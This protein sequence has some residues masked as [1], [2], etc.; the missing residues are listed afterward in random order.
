[1]I[2]K[3]EAKM[4]EVYPGIFLIKEKGGFESFKPEVNIYIIAGPSG[5]IFDAGY[6]GR[7]MADYVAGEIEKIKKLLAS[8]GHKFKLVRIYLS[9]AHPDHFSGLRFL[10]KRIGVKIALTRSSAEI[11]RSKQDYY[12]Y[13]RTDPL[14]DLYPQ[15]G[16]ISGAAQAIAKCGMRYFLSA[17]YGTAFIDNPDLIIDDEATVEINGEEWT[18]FPSPGHARDHIS[19]YNQNKGVLLAGDN[20]LHSITTWLGPP[21][22]NINEYMATLERIAGLKNLKLIL[23]AHGRPVTEPRKRVEEILKLRRR[24]NAQVL[25]IVRKN[26]T[27]GVTAGD[28]GR[29]FYREGSKLKREIGSGWIA[30]TLRHLES[31]GKIRGKQEGH[32]IRFFIA[33]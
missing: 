6:G 16:P 22:S 23:G 7:K 17:L 12:N 11:I 5:I 31:E 10:R 21:H 8:R 29:S 13:Y 26:N 25:D 15:K 19:L 3:G 1:M 33:E 18:I 4:Q 24:R 2:K 14:T 32:A 27:L 9:H 30:I 28:V 20:V